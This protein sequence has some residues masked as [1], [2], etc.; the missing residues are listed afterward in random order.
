MKRTGHC[1]GWLPL[2]E[3]ARSQASSCVAY[4]LPK[5]MRSPAHW[6]KANRKQQAW[7]RRVRREERRDG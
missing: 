1:H 4:G 5:H 7:D 3:W 6:L 2:L